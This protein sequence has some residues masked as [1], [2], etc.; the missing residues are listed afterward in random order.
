ML[1][2]TGA[3]PIATAWLRALYQAI[4]QAMFVGLIT[5]SQTDDTK[6]IVIAAGVAALTALGFRG[7]GEGAFD[8]GRAVN[9]DVRNSDVPVAAPLVTVIENAAAPA[10]GN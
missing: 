4:G 1:S 6:T 9:N 3:S 7:L 8:N 2:M 10:P 5:W